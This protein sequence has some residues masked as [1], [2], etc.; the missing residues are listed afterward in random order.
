MLVI[1]LLH[2][3]NGYICQLPHTLFST[4]IFLIT[5]K[6]QLNSYLINYLRKTV[7]R[8]FYDSSLFSNNF[9][10]LLFI[11]ELFIS[12]QEVF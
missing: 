7:Y 5:A 6:V 12:P 3:W 4:F 9:S 10:E 11:L 1:T 8:I 2:C